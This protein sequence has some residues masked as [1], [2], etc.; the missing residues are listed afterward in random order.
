VSDLTTVDAT[1]EPAGVQPSRLAYL[2]VRQGKRTQIIDLDEGADLLIGR[3]A[4]ATVQLDD[5]RVSREHARIRRRGADILVTDLGGRNGTRLN[6]DILRNQEQRLASGDVIGIGDAELIVAETVRSESTRNERRL[7]GEIDRL[8]PAGG[9]QLLRVVADRPA[10]A[11]IAALQRAV[12][13][14]AQDD[15]AYACL[16]GDGAAATEA[17]F[18]LRAKGISVEPVSDDGGPSEGLWRRARGQALAL[19]DDSG[20]VVAEPRMVRV[21]DLVR[22]V[23]TAPTTVLILGETGAGKE[24]VAEQ[25]HRQSKRSAGPLVR[26]NCGSLPP[27]L[28]ES[29]LFGHE[30]GAF[31]GADRKKLGYLDAADGGT[32]FLDEIGELTLPMQARLLRVLETHS[33]MRVGAHDETTVDVR[34][35]AA[36]NRDLEAEARAGRFREDLY[37]RL[38]AFV[39]EVPPLR[40]RPA[41]IALLT[42]LFVRRFA[43][44]MG[45]T[46]P[47]IAPDAAAAI[48]RHRWP[49][50][51]RELRNAIERAIVL[52]DG[53]VLRAEHLPDAVRGT[54]ASTPTPAAGAG[55]RDQLEDLEQRNIVAALAAEQG[56]QTR[57]AKRLGISR[58]ALIYKMAKFNLGK[59]PT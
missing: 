51:V 16:F 39:I 49:G 35:V 52:V 18:E 50:N 36:T 7:P 5:A 4:D 56:N 14:E 46:P 34:V 9:A 37:F 45:R 48:A 44:R 47:L 42:E 38:A 29:E 40:E 17:L 30:K 27:T 41:E 54:G 59:K 8:R 32:L 57:A 21:F 53:G 13:V 33:F 58:R 2:V 23:A 12:I 6:G 3:S 20:V 55:M 19:P 22:R 28:L 26:L 31:T 11:A 24:V 10:L 15:G 43:T 1:Q 25:I